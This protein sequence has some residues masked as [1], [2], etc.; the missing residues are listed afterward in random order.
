MRGKAGVFAAVT[1]SS[2]AL[3]GVAL[4][5]S[6][7]AVSTGGANSISDTSAALRGSVN[8]HGSATS[9]YFQ[10]GRSDYY[11]TNSG[12]RSAGHGSR[13]VVVQTTAGDLTP[14]ATYHFRLVA[15]NA[16]GTSYGDDHTFTT[17]GSSSGVSTGAVEDLS[18]NGA[19][20]TGSIAPEG[21]KTT[22][23]F[24]WGTVN[25]LSQHTT[26]QRLG[27]T[28]SPQS[29]ASSLSLS[30]ATVYQYRLVAVHPNAT[31]YGSTVTFMTYPSAR[32]YAGVHAI[33]QP[34]NRQ[35]YPYTF[36][37]AGTISG[38]S[39]MPAQFACIGTVH[40]RFYTGSQQRRFEV[41]PVQPNCTF[42]Q[43]TVFYHLPYGTHKPVHMTVKVHFQSTSYLANGS[44]AH[45]KVTIY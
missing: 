38:P 42:S 22:W 3:S 25:H 40:I 33:T 11:G 5:A 7:P 16:S 20:L 21:R 12:T 2:L 14:G 13:Y 1:I 31:D 32:P 34:R 23:Y 45:D 10:W 15:T 19:I 9:Y 44:P 28:T 26:P 43:T 4:A 41:A 35:R 6:S 39:W 29:V 17:H 37:T 36:T 30:P 24:Q 18:T 27:S 8:P